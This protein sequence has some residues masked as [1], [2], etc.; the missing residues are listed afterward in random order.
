VWCV[1]SEES[2]NSERHQMHRWRETPGRRKNGLI[3]KING[4]DKI[5]WPGKNREKILKYVKVVR[6]AKEQ[7]RSEEAC[8]PL[9]P[10]AHHMTPMGKDSVDLHRHHTSKEGYKRNH[11]VIDYFKK[12]TVFIHTTIELTALGAAEPEWFKNLH[13]RDL[14]I[15][16]GVV[17]D[18]GTLKNLCRNFMKELGKVWESRGL[19]YSVS[20]T[21]RRTKQNELTRTRRKF[22]S[23]SMSTTTRRLGAM[24]GHVEFV[25]SKIQ[26][27]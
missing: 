1:E 26:L 14:E 22:I 18:R 3:E 10:F 27:P 12:M 21:N 4:R 13:S 23:D 8:T 11:V 9:Q 6:T 20:S 24:S 16:K 19:P 25:Q 15:P 5:Q 2:E 7:T 17:S